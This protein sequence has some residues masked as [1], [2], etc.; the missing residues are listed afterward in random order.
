MG[1]PLIDGKCGVEPNRRSEAN[2]RTPPKILCWNARGLVNKDSKWK[3]DALKE[4]VSTN[5]VYLMNLTET[6]LKREIQDEKIQNFTTYRSD[7]KSKKK[8]KGGG[9]AIYLKDGFDSRLMIADQVGSCE[10]VAIT[11]EK[12]NIINIVVYRPPDTGY[13]DFVK[14]MNKIEEL[15]SEMATPEPTVIITGDFNFPFIEWKRNIEGACSWKKKTLDNGTLDEQRQF[16]NMMDIMNKY[17]LIQ[18]VEEK[19]RKNNTLDLVFTNDLGIITQIDVTGTIMSDHDIIEIATN[20][21]DNTK[22]TIENET[23][24]Q[25]DEMDLRQLNFHHEQV[26]W[27]E[28]KEILK[29]IPWEKILKGLNNEECTELLIYCIKE[30]CLRK[31]PKKNRKN[32]DHIPRERKKLLNRIKMLKRKK[33]REKNKNKAGSIEKDI[34]DTESELREH[35]EQERDS[36]EER[37][38]NNMKDNPKIFFDYIRKQKDKDTKIG[39]FK[40][41]NDYIYDAKQICKCLIE[42]YNSQFSERVKT[43]TITDNEIMEMDEGDI[44]DIEVTEDEISNA[45]DKLK[46]NS[47]AGPDGIPAVFIIN[48]RDC[49]KIPLRIILRKS[50]DEGNIPDIFK[51]A[52][53]TPIHKGGSKMNPANYRPIS[54]TS[55]IMKVFERVIKMHLIRHLQDNNLVRP[56]QHGFVTGRSTQTQLLQHYSDVFD[57]LIENNRIDTIYLDFAKAFDKVDHHILTK[58]VINHKIKGK[59]AKWIQK[60]LCSEE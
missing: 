43:M 50:L 9:A 33:H 51:L 16:N 49:I 57:A 37:V 21:G 35:R 11:I 1:K 29:V 12:I 18:T 2:T 60:I 24:T 45:I 15:L 31:I 4:H 39:P 46:R 36:K 52:Y 53:I 34:F 26:D 44:S 38:I 27:I 41:G 7:R 3:I 5:N 20:T 55:H 54:L 6:W 17:H 30:I 42:Q 58:K 22:K 14:I 59:I 8:S 56:N 28:I 47:A 10:I 19:T 25:P 40:I 13:D 48:T 23:D 32:R